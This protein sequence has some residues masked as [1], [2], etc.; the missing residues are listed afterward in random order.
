MVV[1]SEASNGERGGARGIPD[2]M[3][4]RVDHNADSLGAKAYR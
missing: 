1:A 4:L 2:G 3:A